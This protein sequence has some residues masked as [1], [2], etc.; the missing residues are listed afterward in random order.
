MPASPDPRVTHQVGRL[1]R[2]LTPLVGREQQIDAALRILR[3]GQRLLTLTGP[4]GVG[5]T[6]LSLAVASAAAH[7][8]PDGT[9]FVSFAPIVDPELVPGLVAAAFQVT[10]TDA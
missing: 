1:P 5:K 10:D 9:P 3:E 7:L 8:F 4:G 6:R 2:T